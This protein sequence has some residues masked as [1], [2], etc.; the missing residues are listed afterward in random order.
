MS[1]EITPSIKILHLISTLDVGGAEQYLSRLVSSR[2]EASYNSIV[3]SMTDIGPIGQDMRKQNVTV[4]S[5]NMK[6]GIPDPRGISRLNR[7]VSSFQPRIIQCWMYHANLLGLLFARNRHLVWNIRCSDM[8]LSRYG[9]VYKCAVRAGA[10]FSKIPDAVIANSFAGKR[11]HEGLGYNPGR[12]EIIPNGFDTRLF[13]PDSSARERMRHELGISENAPV[14]GLIARFDPMK[15]HVTFFHAAHILLRSHLN[16]HF[17]LAGRGI[18]EENSELMTLIQDFKK[19]DNI[20]LLGERSD[21]PQILPALDIVS[22]SSAWG[23]GL[24]NAIGEAMAAGVPC[25]V[26]DVGDSRILVGDTGHVVPKMNPEITARA[27][28]QLIDAGPDHM[29]LLGSK[30][31]KRIE[32]YY[33][34]DSSAGQYD[35]LYRDLIK[36]P[37]TLS[38]L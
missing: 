7:L 5:L 28:K 16:A 2:D 14:I 36:T 23:E 17:I 20:H 19:H 11:F 12:W 8:D 13:K 24:P 29:H 3:V 4:H 34:L 38:S 21:I 31:R 22:L 15:D 25:V 37:V 33:S 27:W 1:S 9:F 26:T 6:K 32:Q 35:Q 18:S 10:A 30:A